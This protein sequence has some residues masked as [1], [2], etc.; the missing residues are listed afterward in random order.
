MFGAWGGTATTPTLEV[1]VTTSAGTR[2]GVYGGVLT[3]LHDLGVDYTVPQTRHRACPHLAGLEA[4]V[5]EGA[6]TDP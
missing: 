4:E 5:G 6:P 2:G 3:R 1:T